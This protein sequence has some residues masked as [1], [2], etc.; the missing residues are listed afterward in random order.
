M[1]NLHPHQYA[2]PQPNPPPYDD[3]ELTDYETATLLNEA[4]AQ[5]NPNIV[6]YN[7]TV[8]TNAQIVIPAV[9]SNPNYATPVVINGPV[10]IQ[11]ASPSVQIP[12]QS[13]PACR[14]GYSR[15]CHSNLS[16]QEYRIYRSAAF[17]KFH[18]FILLILAVALN[19]FVYGLYT[20][21]IIAAHIVMIICGI[22][23]ARRK[24]VPSLFLLVI[25]L[26]FTLVISS[27]I[28]SGHIC[29]FNGGTVITV[30]LGLNIFF[31]FIGI[32]NSLSLIARIKCSRA[33]GGTQQVL[34]N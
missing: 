13:V 5:T 24:S 18:L 30:F 20:W 32:C 2:V 10:I 16:P 25:W 31:M 9:V 27:L 28:L 19:F 4:P 29:N 33:C 15:R 34:V 8:A 14:G 6:Y 17:L 1:N 11:A 22:F 23:G 26:I 3:V 21:L 12:V 7:P